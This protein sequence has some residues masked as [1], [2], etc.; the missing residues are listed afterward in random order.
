MIG[1][2]RCRP[3][4]NHPSEKRIK[5]G[6]AAIS[7]LYQD[8]KTFLFSS[9]NCPE[10]KRNCLIWQHRFSFPLTDSSAWNFMSYH[11]YFKACNLKKHLCSNS[12][13]YAKHFFKFG[14]QWF[15]PDTIRLAFIVFLYCAS[16]G[17]K[18]SRN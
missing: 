16:P 9:N 2:H 14:F 12:I 13:N 5:R 7:I 1:I 18:L 4:H 15:I 17:F 11:V 6:G 8:T 3:L 10:P